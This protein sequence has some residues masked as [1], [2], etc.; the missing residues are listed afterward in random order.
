MVYTNRGALPP[1]QMCRKPRLDPENEAAWTFFCLA[2]T[3]L[4]S[5][6]MG[7]AIGL[8][9]VALNIIFDYHDVPHWQ[10]RW[11]LDDV[12]IIEEVAIRSWNKTDGVGGKTAS[13]KDLRADPRRK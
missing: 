7:G 10:R 13:P 4:R 9:Y 2:S 12:R 6:G 11:L 3:Q 8:D 1:C 5:G